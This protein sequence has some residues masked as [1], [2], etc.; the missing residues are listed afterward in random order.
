MGRQTFTTAAWLWMKNP[1][2]DGDG[3]IDYFG[4]RP[5]SGYIVQLN[6]GNGNFSAGWEMED[7][8][9]T[10]GGIALADF[11]VD[12]DLDALV[13]NGF[14]ETGSFPSRLFW[15]D[16]NGQFTD[17]GQIMNESLGAELAVGDLDLDGDLDVFVAN[18][19]QPNEVWLYENGGFVD[20]GL[21]LGENTDMSGKATLGDL[22]GD[23]DLDIIVGRFRGGAEVWF[24]QTN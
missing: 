3:D 7:A 2:P 9:A 17:S 18:M 13:T 1:L 11:D 23:G 20:S 4:K 8:Q 15:N 16:G 21:R 19:D 10:V 12:G 5:G 24:N 14:R 22:D 6:D